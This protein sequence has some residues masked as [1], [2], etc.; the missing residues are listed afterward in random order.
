[1]QKQQ[2]QLNK[3]VTT[4]SKNDK[5]PEK[6]LISGAMPPSWNPSGAHNSVA[7][8]GSKN[9]KR[10]ANNVVTDEPVELND[11]AAENTLATRGSK[12]KKNKLPRQSKRANLV[13]LQ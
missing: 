10:P 13:S 7:T 8:R 9:G 2:T 1:M 5:L 11:S 6:N 3:Q 12:N 4:K